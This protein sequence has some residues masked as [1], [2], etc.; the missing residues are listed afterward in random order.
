M[1]TGKARPQEDIVEDVVLH[2]NRMSPMG[3]SRMAKSVEGTSVYQEGNKGK[4]I[5]RIQHVTEIK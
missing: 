3:N 2:H 1:D 4:R 5:K